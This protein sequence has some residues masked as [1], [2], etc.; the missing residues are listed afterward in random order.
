MQV[1]SIIINMH[2]KFEINWTKI[3]GS[4]QWGRKFVTH[5][6]KRDLPLVHTGL[7][8]QS[9]THRKILLSSNKKK[10]GTVFGPNWIY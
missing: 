8:C 1:F 9:Q 2:K 6:S 7:N 4:F 10:K 3:K 5:N